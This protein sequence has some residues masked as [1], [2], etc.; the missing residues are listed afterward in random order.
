MSTNKK[1]QAVSQ[2]HF[3]PRNKSWLLLDRRWGKT[4]TWCGCGDKDK[5]HFPRY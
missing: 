1:F 5:N 3:V 2:L 4:Q